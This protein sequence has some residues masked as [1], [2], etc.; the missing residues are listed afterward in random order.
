MA[1]I[2]AFTVS[3]FFGCHACTM[4]QIISINRMVA[5]C[6][7]F[8]YRFIFTKKV[9]RIV[10]AAIWVEVFIVL[11]SFHIFPCNQVGYSP[12]LYV[13]AFVK[14]RPN[15]ERD[16]SIVG[17]VVNRVCLAICISTMFSDLITLIKIIHNK[18]TTR[19]QGM[20]FNRDVR[21]FTQTS[22]QNVTM[23][24]ALV[25]IVVVN[26]ASTNG[27]VSSVLA[28]NTLLVTHVNNALALIL[29]NP[30]VRARFWK[31]TAIENIPALVTTLPPGM[32]AKKDNNW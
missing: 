20:N 16:L 2:I 22:I 12:T 30:E 4:H 13:F 11:A 3:C 29:F 1:G 26:N 10:I 21:F 18:K 32:V 7:P 28:F 17:T 9:C 15:L 8:R 27:P 31:K 23:I 25:M 5:V 14:C 6:F 24:A 19:V